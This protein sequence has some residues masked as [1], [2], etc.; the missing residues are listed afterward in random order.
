MGR[1]DAFEMGPGFEP[2]EGIRS[3][4]SGT[5]PI[6]AM[7]PLLTGLE[8]LEEAGIEAVRAKSVQLTEYALELADACLVDQGITVSSPRDAARRGGHITLSRP[9]FHGLTGQ[10]WKQGVVP[11][12]R[13]PDGIRI[14][15]APLSTS[16]AE[17]HCGMSVLAEL[18]GATGIRDAE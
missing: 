17:V 7:L 10:L 6:L 3:V 4:L 16:F 18:A 9:D 5:P 15:L 14:G 2:A 12:F 11:D 8:M 1:K 13:A